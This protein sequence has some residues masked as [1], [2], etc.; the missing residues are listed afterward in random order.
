MG[1]L[2]NK[3]QQGYTNVNNAILRNN[4][5]SIKERGMLITLISLPDSWEFSISGLSKILPDGKDAIRNSINKLEEQGYVRRIQAKNDKG[6]WD[7][8]DWQVFDLPITE[9]PLADNPLTV[10]PTQVI[11]NKSIT[12]KSITKELNNKEIYN[13]IISYL[14][15][16]TG[17]RYR[18]ASKE[19][20]KH[21][22]ARIAEGYT[23]EDFK[24]VID[25]KCAEWKG[26]EF[27]QYLRP[28]TLFGTKFESYLNAPVIK[29]KTYGQNG[30]EIST[31]VEDDLAG[32][33]G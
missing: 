9:I 12:N 18:T 29:R 27:E 16:K 32:I 31:E 33:F 7:G 15:E 25:K 8:Y 14:N 4:T 19:T 20:Q 26:T 30:V 21:I 23:V 3:T 13:I 28:S 6:Q 1:K 10:E 11:T 2:I 22:H 17:L 5:L 24:T